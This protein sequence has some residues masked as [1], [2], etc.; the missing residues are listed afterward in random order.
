MRSVGKNPDPGVHCNRG[1]NDT[2][3][4]INVFCEGKDDLP[5]PGIEPR[6]PP[7][8]ADSLPTEPPGKPI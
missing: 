3:G 1:I 8:Q 7:L 6:P 4:I 2:P 5:N